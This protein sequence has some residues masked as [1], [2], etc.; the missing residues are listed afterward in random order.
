MKRIG[1]EPVPEL[2]S[3]REVAGMFGV[4]PGTVIRWANEGLLPVIALPSGM[5]RYPAERIRAMLAFPA[6]E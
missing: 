6:D 4:S 1:R 2:L 5:R 3:T